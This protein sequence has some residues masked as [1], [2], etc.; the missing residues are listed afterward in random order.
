MKFATLCKFF[1]TQQILLTNNMLK[2]TSNVKL[3][4]KRLR[5]CFGKYKAQNRLKK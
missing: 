5:F 4:S 3:T 2:N 1:G